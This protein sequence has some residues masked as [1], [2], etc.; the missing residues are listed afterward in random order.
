[1]SP[2]CRLAPIRTAISKNKDRLRPILAKLFEIVYG[3]HL[4]SQIQ[5]EIESKQEKIIN[6]Q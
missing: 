3:Q 1:M 2:A 4:E 6:L 5:K